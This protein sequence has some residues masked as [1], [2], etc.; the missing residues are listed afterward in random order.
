MDVRS[1]SIITR[2]RSY[3]ADPYHLVGVT[4]LG[5]SVAGFSIAHTNSLLTLA[6]IVVVWVALTVVVTRTHFAE[7]A[8][9][10]RVTVRSRWLTTPH[11][12]GD[13]VSEKRP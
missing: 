10:Q 4:S 11:G 6:L 2:V 3:L 13:A 1:T 5:A 12:L 9:L 8:R 7:V